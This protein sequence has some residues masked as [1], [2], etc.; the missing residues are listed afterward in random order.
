ME[1]PETETR[2]GLIT[3]ALN[4]LRVAPLA[5]SLAADG[6]LPIVSPFSDNSHLADIT[7]ELTADMWLGG[8]LDS[9]TVPVDRSRAMAIGTVAKVRDVVVN[10]VAGLP[11]LTMRGPERMPERSIIAQPE[12]GRPRSETLALT[13]DQ[14][15]FYP[16]TYWHVV[17]R[18]AYGWP[19]YVEVVPHGDIREDTDGNLVAIGTRPVNPSD[20]IR[21]PSPLG[22]GLLARARTVLQRAHALN[23]SAALAEDNPVPTVELHDEN[24]TSLTP[25]E[26]AKLTNAWRE[27]RRKGGVAY[28]PKRI[29]MT[30]HG[31]Q[32]SQLLIEARRALQLELVRQAGVS[33]WIADVTV[34]GSTLKYENRALRNYELL[35]LNLSPYLVAI[36]D[37]LTMG[38]VTPRGW[39]VRFDTDQLTRPDEKDRA[40]T[41]VAWV[42][43]G[44]MTVNE[45]RARENLS[46]LEESTTDD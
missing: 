7:P 15:L 43:A 28:T 42:G 30:P 3:R 39:T 44:I 17:E 22:T 32:Q 25:E 18:D 31:Q 45:I 34:E 5:R 16:R 8:A 11:L 41:A 37:R 12:R 29:K 19:A 35:D 9:A 27:A 36:A 40:T 33:A 13:V 4:A 14:M 2:P 46:P 26:I 24:D 20:V 6:E 38:D 21:F 10:G 23:V 1:M